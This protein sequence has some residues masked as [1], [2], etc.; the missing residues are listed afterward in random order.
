MAAGKKRVSRRDFVV[1]SGTAFATGALT[2]VYVTGTAIAEPGAAT[3]KVAYPLST[4]YL[5]YDSRHC[6]GCLQ[7]MLACSLVHDG[8]SSL[9]RA[10]IQV[11]KSVLATYPEDIQ[12]HICRQCPEA[13]CVE[14]CPAG[15]AYINAA[16]GN[17]RM[18]DAKKCIGCQ[19][20]LQACPHTPHRTVWNA[21]INKSSKCDLCVDAPYFNKTGGPSGV[22]AC[23]ST[24]PANA[25]KLVAELPKQTDNDGYDLN[26]APAPTAIA[27]GQHNG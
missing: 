26:I 4:G 5:V 2:T 23:V 21:A 3:K 15:A 16:K 25:L 10:R 17:V 7:C 11:T 14:N 8:E 19:T 9:S 6:A 27:P 13:P 18:I 22:Q 24:C 20:C 1:K 12:I